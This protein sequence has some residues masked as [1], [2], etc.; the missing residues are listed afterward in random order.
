MNLE[1]ITKIATEYGPLI[2]A[3]TIVAGG[4]CLR[5]ANHQ[6]GQPS[7]SLDA[8]AKEEEE[9][10]VPRSLTQAMNEEGYSRIRGRIADFYVTSI[11][12]SGIITD[13]II[14]VPFYFNESDISEI[15]EEAL[16]PALLGSSQKT[17]KICE[18]DVEF[19]PNTKLFLVYRLKHTL[20][21]V[22]YEVN[23]IDDEMI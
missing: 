3:A 23:S 18:M 10:Y 7:T 9:E 20:G 1:E 13:G 5:L 11:G 15:N 17:G 6:L 16:I 4:F 21:S 8:K 14:S 12:Y 19:D 22:D 2:V